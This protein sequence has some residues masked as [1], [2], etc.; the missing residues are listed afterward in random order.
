MLYVQV[1]FVV[2]LFEPS[3]SV[4]G[5]GR[6][7]LVV[8]KRRAKCCLGNWGRVPRMSDAFFVDYAVTIRLVMNFLVISNWQ[9]PSLFV[10]CL[11]SLAIGSFSSGRGVI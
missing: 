11:S 3:G 9:W 8:F 4:L 1:F 6:F 2:L 5:L 7:S 10:R